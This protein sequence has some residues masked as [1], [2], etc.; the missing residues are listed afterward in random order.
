[1]SFYSLPGRH[2]DLHDVFPAKVSENDLKLSHFWSSIFPES[3]RDCG[4][5]NE[6]CIK[7]YIIT[8]AS[9]QRLNANYWNKKIISSCGIVFRASFP[10]PNAVSNNCV[11]MMLCIWV[12][13]THCSCT[14]MWCCW[15]AGPRIRG[16]KNGS[17]VGNQAWQVCGMTLS[18][19][20]HCHPRRRSA[21]EPVH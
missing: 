4:D 10:T 8:K 11:L 15:S 2:T 6:I 21:I 1:M 13:C 7:V 17:V 16:S 12:C 5:R 3:K 9:Y 20:L 19:P 14:W 18:T